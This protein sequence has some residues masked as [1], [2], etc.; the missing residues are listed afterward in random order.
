MQNIGLPEFGTL[1]DFTDLC[2]IVE[3][4]TKQ[5][6]LWVEELAKV[7]DTMPGQLQQFMEHSIRARALLQQLSVS[8]VKY[9]AH[10]EKIREIC[11]APMEQHRFPYAHTCE[12][13]FIS[14]SDYERSHHFKVIS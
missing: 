14:W 7:T 6:S 12:E 9:R 11:V 8:L 3:L 4:Y 2:N 5:D 1:D 13:L 10:A